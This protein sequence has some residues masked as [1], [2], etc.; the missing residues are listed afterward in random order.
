MTKSQEDKNKELLA[1]NLSLIEIET[2]SFCNR[3]CWFCTNTIVDRKSVEHYMPEGVYSRLLDQLAEINFKGELTFSRYNE[4]LARKDYILKKISEAR[5]KLP[6]AIL[7]TNTNGD[8]LTSSYIEELADAGLD[9][10][11]IQQYL[12]NDERYE[13]SEVRR[14]ADKTLERIGFVDNHKVLTDIDGCKLE[15]ELPHPKMTIHL[16]ARNF[17]MDGSSRGGILD[18]ASGY[19]RTEPCKQVHE[20]MYIDW[21]GT[22]M[23][24]C[25]MRSEIKEHGSGVMGSVLHSKLWDIFTSKNYN[26]WRKH[27]E[28]VSPKTGACKECKQGLKPNYEE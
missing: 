3:V 18:L 26:S 7:R 23:V 21:N 13:H 16:R 6:N 11:W 5:E 25:E 4:P 24:C 22:V 12:R 10:L 14:R 20:N 28:G 27:H 9:Q 15:Y 2:F 8:Y 17:G 1:N 19:Q